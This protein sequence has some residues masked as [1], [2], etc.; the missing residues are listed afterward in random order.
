MGKGSEST[1]F[2]RRRT[3]GQQVH[4][5]VPNITNQRGNANQNHMR[6]HLTPVRMA[7]IKKTRDDK[8]RRE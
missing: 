7:V 5:N 2:Q 4:E 1:F 6:Y 8:R 3:N